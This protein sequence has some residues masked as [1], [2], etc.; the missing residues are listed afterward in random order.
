MALLDAKW[1][2]AIFEQETPTGNIDGVNDEFTLSSSP[3]SDKSVQVFVNGLLRRQAT[4]YTISGSVITFNS[5]PPSGSD[6]Y[7]FYIKRS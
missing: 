3:H 5:P 4:D 6:V 2:G 7:C 1:I